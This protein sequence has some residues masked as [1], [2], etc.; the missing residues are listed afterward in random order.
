MIWVYLA[1]D[2][3]GAL[4]LASEPPQKSLL[5]RRPYG[6]NT[7]LITPAMLMKI[8]TQ[9]TYATGV[10]LYIFLY[11][12][13]D[14][15]MDTDMRDI[16]ESEKYQC[17]TDTF[18]TDY[19]DY[20]TGG[21]MAT[22]WPLAKL[23]VPNGRGFGNRSF[24]PNTH[25]TM[26]FHTFVF[27]SL[28]NWINARKI[29]MHEWNFL[30]GLLSNRVFIVVWS[31]VVFI[32]YL[33]VQSGNFL[34]TTDCHNMALRTKS[35]TF[36]EHMFCFV[37]G[38]TAVPVQLVATILIGPQVKGNEF[39]MAKKKRQ[40]KKPADAAKDAIV[41]PVLDAN[42]NV[43]EGASPDSKAVASAWNTATDKNSNVPVG[44]VTA[45]AADGPVG[46]A[47]GA[48]TDKPNTGEDAD[49]IDKQLAADVRGKN[50]SDDNDI[51]E[52]GDTV[53]M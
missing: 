53:K 35:L 31:V 27:L 44:P 1:L 41:A 30:S 36:G 34:G 11:G 38:A 19:P 12:A 45:T 51:V 46:M 23:Q 2:S 9:A 43:V 37:V 8:M 13:S 7:W 42:G 24:Y 16:M 17:D 6:Q 14:K 25:H 3:L 5:N 49:E 32:Q 52:A 10:L 47:P 20:C 4:A 33:V 39:F 22:Y 21:A 18:C 26:I 40:K 50:Y 15:H 48:A 28:F 29:Y